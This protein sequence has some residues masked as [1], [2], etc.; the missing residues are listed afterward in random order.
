MIPSDPT[1]RSEVLRKACRILTPSGAGSTPAGPTQ[2]RNR[3]I[4]RT[5][6]S[7]SR[8]PGSNPGSETK[9]GHVCPTGHVCLPFF[10]NSQ[11]SSE[12]G[13][14]QAGAVVTRCSLHVR[15]VPSEPTVSHACERRRR[16]RTE[17]PY[18]LPVLPG[19]HLPRSEVRAVRLRGSAPA[20]A[21]GAKEVV[22]RTFSARSSSGEDARV[23]SERVRWP[24]LLGFAEGCSGPLRGAIPE[25]VTQALQAVLVKAPR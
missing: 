10:D 23:S 1:S 17:R 4:G 21:G 20:L 16:S 13:M 19:R 2:F 22:C 6:D 11:I 7:E 24:A 5:R 3:P 8:N 9:T 15:L 14:R 12:V 18:R 25:R